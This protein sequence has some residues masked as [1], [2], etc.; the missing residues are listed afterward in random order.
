MHMSF[1]R[2]LQARVTEVTSLYVH[3]MVGA[4]TGIANGVAADDM[5]GCEG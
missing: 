5:I 3:A 2:Y 4:T 1:S